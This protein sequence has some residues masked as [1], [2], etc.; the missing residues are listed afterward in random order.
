[1]FGVIFWLV[2]GAGAL[3]VYSQIRR[4]SGWASFMEIALGIV[5]AA[6][7]ESAIRLS[8]LTMLQSPAAQIVAA[9]A[10]ALLLT[11]TARRLVP[12]KE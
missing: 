8:T 6:A 4:Y 7:A 3:V 12:R 10:G 11:M 1:M 5:G 2:L 9:V